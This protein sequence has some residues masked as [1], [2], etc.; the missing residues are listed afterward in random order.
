MYDYSDSLE[1]AA[2]EWEMTKIAAQGDKPSLLER[3]RGMGRRGLDAASRYSGVSDLRRASQMS[4]EKFRRGFTDRRALADMTKAEQKAAIEAEIAGGRRTLGIVPRV[5]GHD[6]VRKAAIRKLRM[7]GAGKLALTTAGLGLAG[8][9][10][11]KMMD[12]KS[13]YDPMVEA[14]EELDGWEFAKEA[15]LR[16]AEILLA[17]GVDPETFEETYPEHVKLASFPDPEDAYTYE[18]EE[19]LEIYNDMLDEA[20]L[21]IIE[22]LGLI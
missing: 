14:V 10:A 17:N 3:A 2:Y 21:D 11:S 5:R 8:M 15:E 16:A 19:D 1:N 6:S 20:A 18:G 13:S 4:K 9:G 7:Q 12:K 22:D